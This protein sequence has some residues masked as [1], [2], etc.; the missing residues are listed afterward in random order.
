M[1]L[2]CHCAV[3]KS[4]KVINSG[5]IVDRFAG[6]ITV[7]NRG[8]VQLGDR[9]GLTIII[10][11]YIYIYVYR[12]MYIYIISYIYICMSRVYSNPMGV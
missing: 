1:P 3:P 10:Y 5:V 2:A 11:I 7:R 8:S 6:V 12:L 4:R 9:G